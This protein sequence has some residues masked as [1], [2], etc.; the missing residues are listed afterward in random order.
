MRLYSFDGAIE[1]KTY[2]TVGPLAFIQLFNK[3]SLNSMNLESV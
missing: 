1:Y 2:G 3:E